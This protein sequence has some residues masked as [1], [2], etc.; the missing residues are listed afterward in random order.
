MN[1]PLNIDWQQILLHL[2][3]F[4]ILATGLYLLLYRPIKAFMAKRVAY[5]ADM[6]K[7]AQDKLEQ[8]TSLETDYQNKLESV[9]AEIARK[10]QKAQKETEQ[11][12]ATQLQEAK[13][14]ADKLIASARESATMER[15]KILSDAQQEITNLA[16]EATKK[17]LAQ[18][19]ARSV[20]TFVKAAEG[21]PQDDNA[22]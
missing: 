13:D 3:N 6:D 8:A 12:V 16:L 7:Q 18:A 1:I 4:I 10:R 11:I 17:M 20:D 19:Q 14:Q 21:G 22:T 5:Y 15:K 9:N 2:L